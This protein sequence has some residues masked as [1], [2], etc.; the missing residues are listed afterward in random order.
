MDNQIPK[1]PGYSVTLP[2]SEICTDQTWTA[3]LLL[4]STCVCVAGW[5]KQQS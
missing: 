2:V 4:H 5:I 3:L 1:L